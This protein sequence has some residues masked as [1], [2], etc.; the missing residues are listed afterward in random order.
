YRDAPNPSNHD[1][2]N[3]IVLA[4]NEDLMH[5]NVI[6]DADW[7]YLTLSTANM[8][9]YE[10]TYDA[11]MW[12]SKGILDLFY[13]P[14]MAVSPFT[15]QPVSVLEWNEQQYFA[16]L[17][18]INN[19]IRGDFNFDGVVTNADIQAM[20]SA[21]QNPSA[22]KSTYGLTDPDFLTLGNYNG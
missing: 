9:N 19:H 22:F 18:T 11:S 1:P 17:N 2:N 15:T 10:P 21:L 4:Y 13:E 16:V 7:K 3:S 8:G 20:L 12:N 5:G 14:A 6:S